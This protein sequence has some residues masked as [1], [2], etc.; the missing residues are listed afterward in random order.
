MRAPDRRTEPPK[1]TA[2]L[3][4]STIT[5]AITVGLAA[6]AT[7]RSL[8]RAARAKPTVKIANTLAGPLMVDRSGHTMYVLVRDNGRKDDC[9]KLKGCER[10]WPALTTVSKPVA[11]PGIRKSLLGTIPYKGK[12]REVTYKGHPLHTYWYD[13]DKGSVLN[14]GNV[15]FGGSWYALNAKGGLIK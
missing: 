13:T 8:T 5:L 9:R 3:L 12:L 6:A 14:I 7:G 15:Q 11:G 10:N 2:L 4:L 1:R